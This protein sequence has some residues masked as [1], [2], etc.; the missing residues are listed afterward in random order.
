MNGSGAQYACSEGAKRQKQCRKIE[1]WNNGPSC[2]TVDFRSDVKFFNFFA[3]RFLEQPCENVEE[4]QDWLLQRCY[5]FYRK[6]LIRTF[7]A[8]LITRPLCEEE[9]RE[10]GEKEGSS[11]R[12]VENAPPPPPLRERDSE[13]GSEERMRSTSSVPFPLSF[14]FHAQKEVMVRNKKWR[15]GVSDRDVSNPRPQD[16]SF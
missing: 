10:E 1:K 6:E 8:G 2:S 7:L 16:P 4:Y 15:G 13:R 12:G 3:T 5:I 9:G 11:L 14:T